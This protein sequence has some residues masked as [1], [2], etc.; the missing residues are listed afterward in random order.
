MPSTNTEP[1]RVL[2]TNHYPGR[3]IAEYVETVIIDAV[4]GGYTN[5]PDAMIQGIAKLSTNATRLNADA[6]IGLVFTVTQITPGNYMVVMIGTAVT[7]S[8]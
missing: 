2:T 4:T 8:E 6:V 5:V 3:E 1:V 7:L